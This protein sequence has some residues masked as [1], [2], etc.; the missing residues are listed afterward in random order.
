M[1]GAA[2]AA[3]PPA[4]TVNGIRRIEMK[5]A[6]RGAPA[7]LIGCTVLPGS[8]YV[9]AA[10]GEVG[11]CVA[12]E[13]RRPPRLQ[14]AAVLLSAVAC[15][16]S[17][18]VMLEALA[19]SRWAAEFRANATHSTVTPGDAAEQEAPQR[20]P[21]ESAA[22]LDAGGDAEGGCEGGVAWRLARRASLPLQRGTMDELGV[23]AA[24]AGWECATCCD[25]AVS[26]GPDGGWVVS[27][28]GAWG[29]AC[30]SGGGVGVLGELW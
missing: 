26:V 24:A 28:G 8:P 21:A 7:S 10:H 25:C 1:L 27:W 30:K 6:T 20:G 9:A 18:A 5:T 15:A 12:P 11:E 17:A 22:D 29:H 13:S 23:G 14:G 4:A 2:A 19:A 3:P 16:A